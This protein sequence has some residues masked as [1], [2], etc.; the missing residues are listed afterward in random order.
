[1]ALSRRYAMVAALGFL[2]AQFAAAQSRSFEF[3]FWPGKNARRDPRFR[4]MEEG[5]CGEVAK[6]K[7]STVPS[8]NRNGALVA[9]EVLEI[10]SSGQIL[11]RWRIPID[12]H[13]LAFR[14]NWL[15]FGHWSGLYQVDL[16]GRLARY[17]GPQPTGKSDYVSCEGLPKQLVH[18]T[19]VCHFLPDLATGQRRRISYDPPCT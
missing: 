11:R 12:T 2:S 5:P 7:V 16:Q 3:S 18:E 14:S 19:T 17:S 1:M 15:I 9:E 8:V 4:R 6:A 13:V 10:N